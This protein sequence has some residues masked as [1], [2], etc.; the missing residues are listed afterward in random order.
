VS[1]VET[2]LRGN[3]FGPWTKN[4]RI[5]GNLVFDAPVVANDERTVAEIIQAKPLFRIFLLLCRFIV[6]WAIDEDRL[7]LR[8]SNR[9]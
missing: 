3:C 1:L 2:L 4:V 7:A 6:R 8:S 5:F 9:P